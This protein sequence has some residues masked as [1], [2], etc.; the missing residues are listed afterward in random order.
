MSQK[1]VI[2]RLYV[3]MKRSF[4][5][6]PSTVVDTMKTLGLRHRHQTVA[7]PN[8]AEVRGALAKIKHLVIV[9]TEAMYST[10]IQQDAIKNA[11]RPPIVIKHSSLP[12][13]GNYAPLNEAK[14]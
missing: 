12:T 6:T 2:E 4:A 11:L 13:S 10:R 5:G 14:V 1:K 7:Q 8:T 3:T 9:E